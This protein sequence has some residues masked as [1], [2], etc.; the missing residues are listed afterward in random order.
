MTQFKFTPK[1]DKRAKEII[2]KYPKGKQ[3]SALLPLLDIAQRQSDNWLPVP[4]IEYVASYLDMPFIRAME[5]AS[6]YT[7]FN[8]TPVGKFHVQVCGTTPCMLRD[9]EDIKQACEQ[10]LGIKCGQT[11]HDKR[12][13]LSE[14]EC[15][16]ACVNAPMVQIND[17]FY[18]DLTKESVTSILQALSEGKKV[19]RGTQKNR[20]NSKAEGAHAKA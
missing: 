3:A 10:F 17:D 16:G 4:V 14:V 12:F 11:T 1:N 2:A 7:M 13:T 19:K 6:F 20:L 8:L 15:L 5:V 9:A 18:E